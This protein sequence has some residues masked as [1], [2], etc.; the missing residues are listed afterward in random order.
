LTVG[1]HLPPGAET[2]YLNRMIDLTEIREWDPLPGLPMQYFVSKG[3]SWGTIGQARWVFGLSVLALTADGPIVPVPLARLVLRVKKSSMEVF[4]LV[5][6][7]DGRTIPF[8]G[9]T[10]AGIEA[11]DPFRLDVE[12]LNVAKGTRVAV[13]I[14]GQRQDRL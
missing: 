6:G 14:H 8:S 13:I 4:D 11:G 5:T 12:A 1:L 3:Q 7:Y 9:L 10:L 2:K